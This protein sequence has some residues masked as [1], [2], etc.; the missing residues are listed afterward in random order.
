MIYKQPLQER[1]LPATWQEWGYITVLFLL[2]RMSKWNSFAVGLYQASFWPGMHCPNFVS[3][4]RQSASPGR[5]LQTVSRYVNLHSNV[6]FALR[7]LHFH[8]IVHF[9]E[10]AF[11]TIECSEFCRFENH[12]LSP[13]GAWQVSMASPTS[14]ISIW[15][16]SL[17]IKQH[18]W[19]LINNMHPVSSQGCHLVLIPGQIQ[20][21]LVDDICSHPMVWWQRPGVSITFVPQAAGLGHFVVKVKQGPKASVASLLVKFKTDSMTLRVINN[22]SE[23]SLH[24]RTY[25]YV[26]GENCLM[27][28]VNLKEDLVVWTRRSQVTFAWWWVVSTES[29]LDL[30]IITKGF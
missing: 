11:T 30:D 19:P 7:T 27:P 10:E 21:L 8:R 1:W 12:P 25:I 5:M 14:P 22:C 16:V 23:F 20:Q 3:C 2:S 15:S 18:T 6:T 24:C 26:P 29:S 4:C 9:E 28:K 13:P 17:V